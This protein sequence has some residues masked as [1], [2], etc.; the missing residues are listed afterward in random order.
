[1]SRWI[2]ALQPYRVKI[3]LIKGKHNSMADAL[4]RINS[5]G[6]T[7]SVA[8]SPIPAELGFGTLQALALPTAFHSFA[9]PY[10]NPAPEAFYSLDPLSMPVTG[11]PVPIAPE[12]LARAQDA[13]PPHCP[14]QAAS[15]F[16]GLCR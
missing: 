16:P 15:P 2:L 9:D 11:Q 12:E 7:W 6:L 4:S 10:Y 8:P 13:D 1:M 14:H 3:E 5:E